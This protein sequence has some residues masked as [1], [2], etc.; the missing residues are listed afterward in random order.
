MRLLQTIPKVFFFTILSFWLASCHFGDSDDDGDDNIYQ[1]SDP[2]G[3]VTELTDDIVAATL[4]GDDCRYSDIVPG[5]TYDGLMDEFSITTSG[6]PEQLYLGTGCFQATLYLLNTSSSCSSGCEFF[7][8][9]VLAKA[10]NHR[11]WGDYTAQINIDLIAGTYLVI[12]E[13]PPVGGGSC[14]GYSVNNF[15]IP[16]PN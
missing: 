1:T 6:G 11:A 16:W 5:T 9:M 3:T 15:D 8:S 2:C 10:F 14:N 7:D 13:G 12:V 4:G